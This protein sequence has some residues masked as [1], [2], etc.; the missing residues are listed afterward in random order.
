MRRSAF[1]LLLLFLT[2]GPLRADP[3][4]VRYPQGTTHGFLTLRTMEGKALATG[5]LV[6]I[7][8]GKQI[9]SRL[10]FRFHDG[11]LDDEKAVFTQTGV[12]H[13]VTDHHIQRGPSY[14]KPLDMSIDVPSGTVV[15]REEKKG[16]APKVKT[17]HM[18]LP[19]D[20]ANGIILTLMTN[21]SDKTP[22]TKLSYVADFGGA[23]VIH[24]HITSQGTVP[25]RVGGSARP[26]REFTAKVD[27][28]GIAG[29]VA[30]VIGKQPKDYK[31]L[32]LQ[33]TAPAFVREEGQLYPDGPVWR[34]DQVGPVTH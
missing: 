25:F 5:D 21:I 11:S 27:L 9:V 18:D 16:E 1:L 2:R 14:P 24:I 26:A 4:P 28:G 3:I 34:I 8:R 23:R 31:L 22:E 30:P 15:T 6:Q 33:G 10:T 32:I 19:P 7:V 12:F 17:Q 13:L 29:V 20:L